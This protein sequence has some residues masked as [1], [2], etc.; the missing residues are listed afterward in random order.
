MIQNKL[1][2]ALLIALLGFVLVSTGVYAQGN[3]GQRKEKPLISG[4]VDT[5]GTNSVVVKE[6]AGSKKEIK[7]DAQTKIVGSNKKTLPLHSLKLTDSIILTSTQSATATESGIRAKKIFVK[8]ATASAQMKRRAVQ[9][10]ISSI[11]GNTLTLRHQVQ[12]ER[13]YAVVVSTTTVITQ[14][15]ATG[16]ATLASLAVGQRVI[17][18][19]DV[20]GESILAKK[21]HIIPGKAT[22][23]MNKQ[24]VASPVATGSASP[25]PTA[26]AS[27]TASPSAS[28]AL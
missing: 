9:G 19:G 4:Q 27:A 11:A 21:I 28:P 1:H 20:S 7:L 26:S 23:L 6:K 8:D 12:S 13:T 25:S 18:V 3:S 10:I 5:I 2:I 15:D 17:A 22:G 16:S 24:P 14:K